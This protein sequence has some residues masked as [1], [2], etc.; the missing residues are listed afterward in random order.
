MKENN[1]LLKENQ[2]QR[3]N[4]DL[5]TKILDHWNL[6]VMHRKIDNFGKEICF[7]RRQYPLIPLPFS[8]QDK[9]HDTPFSHKDIQ[10]RCIVILKDQT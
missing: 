3:V 2:D 5:E 7:Q 6:F 1:L 8:N 9:K 10:E 4:L